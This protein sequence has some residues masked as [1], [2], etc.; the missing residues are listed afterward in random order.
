MKAYLIIEDDPTVPGGLRIN[1]MHQASFADMAAGIDIKN[2]VPAM[3]VKEA[4]D[5]IHEI[6]D[7]ANQLAANVRKRVEQRKPEQNPCL[8]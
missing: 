8:H 2:T 5:H 7:T 6:V 1:V 3:M 4:Y